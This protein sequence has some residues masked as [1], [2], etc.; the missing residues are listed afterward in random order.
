[1]KT[2]KFYTDP[3]HGWLA[4]KRS[5]IVALGIA[6][7]ISQYSYQKGATCY[8]EEDCDMEIF[9]KAKEDAG[10]KLSFIG[11]VTKHTDNRSPIRSY[12]RFTA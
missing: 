5:E 11:F 3:G 8:L 4:V 1:M 12:D 7:K 6:D 9:M 2:Y 10:Q